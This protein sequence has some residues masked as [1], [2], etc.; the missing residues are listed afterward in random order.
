MAS[1][2]VGQQHPLLDMLCNVGPLVVFFSSTLRCA[3]TANSISAALWRADTQ[4]HSAA[5]TFSVLC[6]NVL[7]RLQV[8]TG[9]IR[10]NMFGV[11]RIV[12]GIVKDSLQNT[13]K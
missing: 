13:Y 3:C 6:S 9:H 7:R 1:D 10:V 8:L 4:L 12:E 5:W 11:G 2:P